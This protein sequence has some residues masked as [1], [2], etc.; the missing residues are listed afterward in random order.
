MIWRISSSSFKN[1]NQNNER[2]RMVAVFFIVR[3]ASVTRRVRGVGSRPLVDFVSCE[4]KDLDG[5]LP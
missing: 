2:I 4:G 3:F 1:W 5:M